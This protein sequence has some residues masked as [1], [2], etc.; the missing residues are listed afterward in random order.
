MTT[1]SAML[2]KAKKDEEESH[3][4]FVSYR[5]PVLHINEVQET[6]AVFHAN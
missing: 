1:I 3:P 6:Q 5:N 2:Q 4:E